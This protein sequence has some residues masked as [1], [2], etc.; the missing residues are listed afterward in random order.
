MIAQ[1]VMFCRLM[2]GATG[3]LHDHG[4]VWSL[5]RR[6]RRR[7]RRGGRISARRQTNG[8]D[9]EDSTSGASPS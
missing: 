5:E 6:R 1:R 7:R 3:T 4:R 9:F 8:I 2:V